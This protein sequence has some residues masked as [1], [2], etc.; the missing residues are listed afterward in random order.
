MKRTEERRVPGES[1]TGGRDACYLAMT[2]V[3]P[4]LR[5]SGPHCM[6]GPNQ[7]SGFALPPCTVTPAWGR[8]TWECTTSP[9]LDYRQGANVQLGMWDTY[10]S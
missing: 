6:G 2:L 9:V 7:T 3:R 10:M 4:L 1:A 5:A 8:I